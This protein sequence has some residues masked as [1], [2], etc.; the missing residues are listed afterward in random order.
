M[1]NCNQGQ[2]V[3]VKYDNQCRLG[4]VQNVNY[5]EYLVNVMCL[6]PHSDSWWRLYQETDA[7]WFIQSNILEHAEHE[8]VMD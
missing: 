6:K 4:V 2:W 3:Y 7:V 5:T 8:P 1:F